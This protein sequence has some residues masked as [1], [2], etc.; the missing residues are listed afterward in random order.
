MKTDGSGALGFASYLL[1]SETTNGQTVTGGVRGAITTLT[2]AA[3]ITP[4]FD[5][6]VNFQVTL[7]TNATL[8]N[9]SNLTVGQSGVIH[10]IQDGTGSRTL[11]FGSYFKFPGGTAPTLSTAAGSTDAIAYSVLSTTHITA[12]ASL[13]V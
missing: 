7:G 5:D 11:S 4:D 3:T 2:S 6:N 8:A 1:L 13:N 12:V 10:V 9:P